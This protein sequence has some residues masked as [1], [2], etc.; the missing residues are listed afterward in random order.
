MA[1]AAGAVTAHLRGRDTLA[2]DGAL[3]LGA[4][5]TSTSQCT[6]VG[7]TTAC[8]D[9]G[10]VEDGAL[11][12]CRGAGGACFD[13]VYSA[14]CCSGLYCREG[15][16]TDLSVTG[17]LPA[18]SYCVSTSQCSQASGPT[19]CAD[20]GIVEDGTRNCCLMEGGSCGGLDA[21]C[22]YGLAC[23]TDGICRPIST[24][25]ATSTS[26]GGTVAAGGACTSSSQCSAPSICADNGLAS[27]GTLNCCL[28]ETRS[29]A[30]DI[31]CCA[32][33][34]CGD[35]YNAEDGPLNCCAP[36]GGWCSSDATCCDL[37]SCVNGICQAAGTA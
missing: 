1:T 30:S 25:T 2:Q 13:T 14:D 29:C 17:E 37:A 10:Y 16:C 11:N 6:Q 27:D 26:G 20:N 33:L 24:S 32:G 23:A 19:V 5:C 21:R 15:V 3:P 36:A 4:A 35:N 31:E 8:A 7:G 18:G 9:N 28:T 34:I 12:C 22:C